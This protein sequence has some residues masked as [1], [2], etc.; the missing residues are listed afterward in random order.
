MEKSIK[1]LDA[2]GLKSHQKKQLRKRGAYIVPGPSALWSADG[3]DKLAI[4]GF[5]IYAIVDAYSRFIIHLFVGLSNQTLVA[6]QKY[7]LMAVLLFGIPLRIRTDKGTETLLMAACQMLLRQAAEGR[8]LEVTDCHLFGKSIFNVHVESLWEEMI[9][10]V[11]NPYLEMFSD[12][13][14]RDLFTEGNKW[15]KMA[16]RFVYMEALR[17][18]I[19]NWVD[20]WNRHLIR[21]QSNRQY[22]PTGRPKYLYT[23]PENKGALNCGQKADP[24]V[25][26]SL[27][28]E[29]ESYDPDEY[30]L[31]VVI[32]KCKEILQAHSLPISFPSVLK[33]DTLHREAYHM[34]KTQLYYYETG[35]GELPKLIP[36]RGGR[37]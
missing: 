18:D 9:S 19:A 36:P 5:Q 3:H 25:L 22:L 12:Y 33:G 30:L 24:A 29:V 32:E 23:F 1:K 15:H 20:D 2:A 21:K 7:Y 4:Y 13:K 10:H 17:C 26:E 28:A 31:P 34:L 35:G 14:E 27:L 16:M 8:E 6:I 11:T 37:N